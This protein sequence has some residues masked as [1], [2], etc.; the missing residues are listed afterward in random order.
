MTRVRDVELAAVYAPDHMGAAAW[1]GLHTRDGWYSFARTS[2]DTALSDCDHPEAALMHTDPFVVGG[3][4]RATCKDS[5]GIIASPLVR[6]GLRQ[7]THGLHGRPGGTAQHRPPRW[8]SVPESTSGTLP[9]AIGRFIPVGKSHH[10][11]GRITSSEDRV[12]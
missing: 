1:T 8:V 6:R 9:L 2:H 4:E 12:I 11:E 10:P 7:P 5:S 3:A